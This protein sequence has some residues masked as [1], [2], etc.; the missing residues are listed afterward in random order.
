M[1]FA[2]VLV[3]PLVCD[4]VLAPVVVFVPVLVEVFVDC[5]A[6]D[7]RVVFPR[8]VFVVLA[9]V[10]MEKDKKNIQLAKLIRK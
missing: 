6:A 4:L 8:T 10:S 1:F 9:N 7:F 3:T 2:A 5:L